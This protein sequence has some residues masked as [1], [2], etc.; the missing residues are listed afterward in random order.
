MVFGRLWE[1]AGC[2]AVIEQLAAGRDF[3]LPLERA[4]F[5]SVLHRLMV[6]G[7]DRACEKW[8]DGYQIDGADGL[9]LHQLYRAM[10]WLGE[11]LADQS[12][13]THRQLVCWSD[14]V[15]GLARTGS[16]PLDFLM[17]DT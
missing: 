4:I 13:A 3:G 9:E 17:A 8:L 10:A 12:G 5:V 14:P 16:A 6:S 1:Q 7:S 15:I 2:R 11:E